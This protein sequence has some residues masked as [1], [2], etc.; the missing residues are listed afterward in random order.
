MSGKRNLSTSAGVTV[1]EYWTAGVAGNQNLVLGGALPREVMPLADGTLVVVDEFDQSLTLTVKQGVALK[2][3]V[4]T[5]TAAGSTVA[6][7]ATW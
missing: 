7:Q 1:R 4:Q 6:V 5:L 3:A 2:C